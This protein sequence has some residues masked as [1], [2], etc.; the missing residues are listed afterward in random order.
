MNMIKFLIL[1]ILPI[2]SFASMTVNTRA[3]CLK[4][5]DSMFL[6]RWSPRAFKDEAIP[7]EDL[8]TIFEAARWAPSC[9]NEQPWI[10]VYA[11]NPA[12][13]KKVQATL[14]NFNKAW[15]SKAPVLVMLFAKKTFDK[16]NKPNPW[17]AFD[18]GSSWMSLAL[19]AKKLGFITHAMGGFDT[20]KA[21]DVAGLDPEHYEAITI[22][23]IGKEGDPKT[24]PEF[25]QKEE[26]VSS[27]KSLNEIVR[28]LD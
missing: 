27:R 28:Q 8:R 3:T 26:V 16:N 1:A 11:Q 14:V 13:L 17:S 22:I 15:A 7:E 19:H 4:N 10:Y 6:S 25:L 21:L 2:M 23:A 24:L 18:A 5:L 9:H 20:K 12:S